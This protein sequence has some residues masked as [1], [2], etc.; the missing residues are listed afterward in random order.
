MNASTYE[1]EI[2]MNMLGFGIEA[3]GIPCIFYE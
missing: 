2:D 3:K 1:I